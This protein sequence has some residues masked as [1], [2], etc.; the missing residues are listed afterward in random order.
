MRSEP[1]ECALGF[2]PHFIVI[3]AKPCSRSKSNLQKI[4]MGFL[5]ERDF[6]TLTTV[7]AKLAESPLFIDD[8]AGLTS[9]E[10]R[11]K[12]RRLKSQHDIQLIRNAKIA[13]SDLNLAAAW[14]AAATLCIACSLIDKSAFNTL[15]GGFLF[16]AWG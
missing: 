14:P 10:L 7:A 15:H 5:S 13:S 1:D 11:A 9:A 4:R 6:P 8:T 12:A 16:P 3:K 2:T